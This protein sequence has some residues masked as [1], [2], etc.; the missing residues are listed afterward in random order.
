MAG[1][2]IDVGRLPTDEYEELL[3]SL[4]EEFCN[5]LGVSDQPRV[6]LIQTDRERN[7]E[8]IPDAADGT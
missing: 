2:R 7:P 4:F 1:A 8:P 3:E 6:P 5:Q